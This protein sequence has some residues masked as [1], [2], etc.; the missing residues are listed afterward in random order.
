MFADQ[1]GSGAVKY[2][3]F[4]NPP[5][6]PSKAQEFPNLRRADTT[7]AGME[8]LPPAGT[9]EM[10][11]RRRGDRDKHSHVAEEPDNILKFL[12]AALIM[13][14]NTLPT[15]LQRELFEHADGI[16]DTY[17]A[18]SLC[19]PIAR[20]FQDHEDD[21]QETRRRREPLDTF[22]FRNA[23]AKVRHAV[24]LDAGR[25]AE[26][27]RRQRRAADVLDELWRFSCE[28]PDAPHL[29]KN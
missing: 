28:M 10:A 2:Q 26:E 12:G 29:T 7:L 11:S 4:L 15:K 3:E 8:D 5:D 6:P 21:E 24:I 23:T 19:E 27:A 20:F 13:R 1:Y 9:E 14:W 17:Q 25:Q 18:A 16:G 22:K